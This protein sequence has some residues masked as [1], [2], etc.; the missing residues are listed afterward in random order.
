MNT[1][2]AKQNIQCKKILHDAKLKCTPSRLTILTLLVSKH[3][4][5]S[6]QEIFE[7]CLGKKI[8]LVTIYRTLASLEKARIIRRLDLRKDA[9]LYEFVVTHHHHIVCTECGIVEDFQL[10]DI[11]NLV[12]K[13]AVQAKKFTVIQEHTFELFGICRNCLKK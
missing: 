6:A 4:P 5:F 3:V 12:K 1:K 11:D 8:D 2:Q 10:C 13:I 9:V 7:N